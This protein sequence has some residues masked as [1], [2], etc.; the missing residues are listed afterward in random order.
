MQSKVSCS[1]ACL[2]CC[3]KLLIKLLLLGAL[4]HEHMACEHNLSRY[5]TDCDWSPIVLRLK[6]CFELITVGSEAS[7]VYRHVLIDLFI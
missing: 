4:S 6:V 1:K 5:Q 2:N 7:S 3:P